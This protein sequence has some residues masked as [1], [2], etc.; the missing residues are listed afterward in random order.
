MLLCLMKGMGLSVAA[1]VPTQQGRID[2]VL[3]MPD[4]IYV[5]EIKLNSSTQAA[6][7][8]IHEKGYFQPYLR[9]GKQLALLGIN[10]ASKAR[11]IEAWA[12]ELRDEAGQLL[13]RLEP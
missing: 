11:N 13:R 8:Q 3:K 1:E 10:F 12:G 6:L 7:D 9:Q 5:I 4:T 2:L